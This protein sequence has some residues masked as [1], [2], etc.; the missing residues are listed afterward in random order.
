MRERLKERD[1]VRARFFATF[2]RFGVKPA[3]TWAPAIKTLLL[4]D[5][6]DDRG[7]AVADHVW[8]KEGEWSKSLDLKPG[9]RIGFDARV[10]QYEKGY[11]GRRDVD[12]PG[13]SVDYR[14][15][16][17]TKAAKIAAAAIAPATDD[18]PQTSFKF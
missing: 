5:V 15:G 14:L 10:S 2:Q 13:P 6:R 7:E 4:V 8:F 12:A 17:P 11:R 18:A 1:G 3:T 9:D 16:F